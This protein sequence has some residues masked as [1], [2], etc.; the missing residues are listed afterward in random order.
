MKLIKLFAITALTLSAAAFAA[1]EHDQ[2]L[3][4]RIQA[5]GEVCT[6][7]SN[8]VAVT[9][10]ANAA[11]AGAASRSGADIVVKH[12]AMCHGTPGIPGAPRTAEEWQARVDA[13]GIDGLVSSAAAGINAMPPKGL[14]MDCTD[15]EFKAAVE[16]L[17]K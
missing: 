16:E 7:G 4:E 10:V 12:C 5:V 8:C 15:A 6:S 13:K 14:C 17:V 2:A 1:D 11:T 3:I 9:T